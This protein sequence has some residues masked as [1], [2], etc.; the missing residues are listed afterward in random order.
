[1]VENIDD[2]P[3]GET[4]PIM[5]II[6]NKFGCEIDRFYKTKE[7]LETKLLALGSPINIEVSKTKEVTEPNNITDKLNRHIN[8]LQNIN[9]DFEAMAQALDE[10]V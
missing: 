9:S 5:E 7:R 6:C 8:A 3:K 10:T 4:T 1:M 2:F